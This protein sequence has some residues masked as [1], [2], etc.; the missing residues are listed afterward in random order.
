MD[1]STQDQSDSP[2]P[3][4]VQPLAEGDP[5]ETDPDGDPLP[6]TGCRIIVANPHD[7][8]ARAN[9]ALLYPREIH[10]QVKS[11]CPSVSVPAR[12]LAKAAS[13]R[14]RWWGVPQI[15][16]QIP[17]PG[18]TIVDGGNAAQNIKTARTVKVVSAV[19]CTPGQYFR[20]MTIGT[21]EYTFPNGQTDRKAAYMDNPPGGEL[22]CQDN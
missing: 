21:G 6:E 1:A 13:Y 10:T 3:Q 9:G 16:P 4:D 5:G 14:L 7:S 17:K 22:T 19:S 2:S 8:R 18:K 15:Q 12:N 20:W 11:T